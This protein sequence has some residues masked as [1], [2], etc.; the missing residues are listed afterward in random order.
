MKKYSLKS[1]LLHWSTSIGINTAIFMYAFEKIQ[2][3]DLT[4]W[5]TWAAV[6]A[7]LYPILVVLII[8]RTINTFFFERVRMVDQ[9][10]FSP[11]ILTL[12]LIDLGIK[13]Y[14]FDKR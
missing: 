6:H 13:R 3:V 7:Y 10:L 4:I 14:G 1:I 8:L 5:K 11:C 2:A 9:T 12:Q